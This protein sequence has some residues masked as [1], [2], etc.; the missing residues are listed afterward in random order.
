MVLLRVSWISSDA[1]TACKMAGRRTNCNQRTT[2]RP[3]TIKR[4]TCTFLCAFLQKHCDVLSSTASST[5]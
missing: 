2:V 1:V 3:L 4:S 5:K